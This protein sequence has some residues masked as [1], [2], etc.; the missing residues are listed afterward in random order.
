MNLPCTAHPPGRACMVRLLGILHIFG[1]KRLLAHEPLP[2]CLG[3]KAGIFDRANGLRRR[4]AGC[5]LVCLV[6]GRLTSRISGS[7]RLDPR[8]CEG[9]AD[10]Q[11]VDRFATGGICGKAERNAGPQHE[12]RPC[13]RGKEYHRLHCFRPGKVEFNA[14][15]RRSFRPIWLR[16]EGCE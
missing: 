8:G 10:R 14:G 5:A 7:W 1:T 13:K 6:S 12:G 3:L 4:M 2:A 11:H 16:A 15:N 9:E